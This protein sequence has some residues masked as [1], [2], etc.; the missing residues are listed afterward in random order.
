MG[1]V[2][3]F[4]FI[5]FIFLPFLSSSQKTQAAESDV[6]INKV[7][8]HPNTD[9]VEWIELFNINL[10]S[11]SLTGYTIEDGTAIPKDLS[12]YSIPVGGYL[13]LKKGTDFSFGLND[14]G[15]IIKLKELDNLVDQV[16]YGNWDDGNIADNAPTPSQGQSIARFPNGQDTDMASDF[17]IQDNPTSVI[18]E[19]PEIDGD[20]VLLAWS[21]AEKSDFSKYEIFQSND[22]GELGEKIVEIDEVENN[23][24][25]IEDLNS[26]L[27]YDFVIKNYN[28]AGVYNYSNQVSVILPIIYPKTVIVNEI[29]PHPENGLENEFIELYNSGDKDVDLSGWFLDD[30]EEGS[31]PYPIPAGTII[32]SGEYKVFYK[33]QTNIALNDSG[34]TARLLFPDSQIASS[35]VY[36]EYADVGLSWA[37][38]LTG[39]WQ[40][41]TTPTAEKI[42]VM[43]AVVAEEENIDSQE[44]ENIPINTTPVEIKTGEIQ[45]YE[46]YLVKITG[47]VV[48]T[49][50]NT[51]YLDDGSG[52][53]KVYIQESTGIEKPPMHRGDIFEIMGIIDLYRGVWRVL[54]QRKEDIKLIKAISA[55]NDEEAKSSVAKAT[56]AKSSTAKK[57]TA[58]VTKARSPTTQKVAGTNSQ[59]MQTKIQSYRSSFWIQMTK[60]V[61]GLSVILLI[62]LIVKIVQVKRESPFINKPLGGDFGDDT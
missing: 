11:I 46:N 40:W 16:T 4:I 42:N 14:S 8:S 22:S 51:F 15:D 54:P 43:T 27:K 62:L 12:S 49:S 32:L 31:Q 36:N 60:A 59:D 13:V 21:K 58:A 1:K 30:G 5:V 44:E 38:G 7:Y 10:Q 45:N 52:Q 2:K 34:D 19:D 41:T 28:L 39:V 6:V 17:I 53:A 57:S 20:F 26:G 25:E 56:S 55:Q 18:L 61:S 9:E 29:L 24:Y 37:R 23:F 50:G 3:Y 33:S 48:E 47:V 35:R